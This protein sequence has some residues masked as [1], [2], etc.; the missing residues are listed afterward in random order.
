M[1]IH[2][3]EWN[4][5]G[6][7]ETYFLDGK[8]KIDKF[9]EQAQRGFS[10]RKDSQFEAATTGNCAFE[11]FILVGIASKWC[12]LPCVIVLLI[13]VHI[14]PYARY[15]THETFEGSSKIV[16]LRYSSDST[17]AALV[18]RVCLF[19]PKLQITIYNCC[20]VSTSSEVVSNEMMKTSQRQDA[21]RYLQ[22]EGRK[23][24]KKQKLWTQVPL[25]MKWSIV[26]FDRKW[27]LFRD[28]EE[29]LEHFPVNCWMLSGRSF[30]KFTLRLLYSVLL[31]TMHSKYR[32]F[33]FSHL[34][35]VRKKLRW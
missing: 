33:F 5:P 29:L 31:E 18:K 1:T 24:T 32:L 4:F 19:F 26:L 6:P 7:R 3:G 35:F 11:I 16:T 9:H 21:F 10:E 12:L 20:F 15:R 13:V 25:W 2:L 22:R 14:A 23:E 28:T 8:R 30:Y 17:H 34:F 27:R